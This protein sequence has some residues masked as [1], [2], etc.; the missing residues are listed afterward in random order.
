MTPSL[1]NPHI[2]LLRETRIKRNRLSKTVIEARGVKIR[3]IGISMD[4]VKRRERS[5]ILGVKA[6]IS[7]S[8]NENMIMSSRPS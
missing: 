8:L 2:D 6:L 7:I 3:I 1:T 5:K 4:K